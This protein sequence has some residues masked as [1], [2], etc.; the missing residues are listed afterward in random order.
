MRATA[1]AVRLLD[2][3]DWQCRYLSPLRTERPCWSEAPPPFRQLT[4][5]DAV[6]LLTWAEGKWLRLV[7]KLE[8]VDLR[9]EP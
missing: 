6:D 3:R 7:G 5:G 4:A 1:Y 8:V 9:G 2:L